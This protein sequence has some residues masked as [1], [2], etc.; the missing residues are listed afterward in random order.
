[1]GEII[2]RNRQLSDARLQCDRARASWDEARTRARE[3]LGRW[4]KVVS[5][6]VSCADLL[7]EAR[8]LEGWRARVA[9]RAAELEIARTAMLQ[10]EN[11]AAHARRA[12]RQE[13]AR[14][15][16]FLKLADEQRKAQEQKRF[17]AQERELEDQVSAGCAVA[18]VDVA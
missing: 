5:G 15:E 10:A 2:A 6:A 12:Y 14:R 9:Q 16:A 7:R 11:D 17:S 1:M 18:L 13:Y 4:S 3:A 8:S